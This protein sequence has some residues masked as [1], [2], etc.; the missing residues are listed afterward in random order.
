MK[1]RDREL[2]LVGRDCPSKYVKDFH[3]GL[4][5]VLS[6]VH[7]IE[8]RLERGEK[9]DQTRWRARKGQV[10]LLSWTMLNHLRNLSVAAVMR[11]YPLRRK[12]LGT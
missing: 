3:H 2:K 11:L 10:E 8:K 9:A 12:L 5:Q 4:Y 7:D 1:G 6:D